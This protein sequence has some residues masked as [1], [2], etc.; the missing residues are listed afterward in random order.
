MK[1]INRE[2]FE[3]ALKQCEAEPIHQ[4]G[5]IQPHGA[6][7][8]INSDSQR[9]VLQASDNLADFVDLP[10]KGVFGKPLTEL[11]GETAK[12][13]IEKLIQV[14]EKKNTAT[15]VISVTPLLADGYVRCFAT[16][17]H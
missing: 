7:L 8:V 17:Q 15:G 12:A 1:N 9:T 14:A 10:S 11:L 5:N 16:S 6:A 3:Y 4:I 13:Q 2:E